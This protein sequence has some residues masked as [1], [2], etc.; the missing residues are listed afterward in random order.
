[1]GCVHRNAQQRSSAKP[2]ATSDDYLIPY[3]SQQQPQ[4][5]TQYDIIQLHQTQHAPDAAAADHYDTLNPKTLGQ[6][7]HQYDFIS[8]SPQSDKNTAEYVDVN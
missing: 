8:R 3:E 2:P 1:M 4:Q 6:Q 5:Q 7:Q